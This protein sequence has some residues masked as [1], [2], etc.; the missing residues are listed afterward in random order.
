MYC[1]KRAIKSRFAAHRTNHTCYKNTTGNKKWESSV[2]IYGTDIPVFESVQHE[3]QNI[4]YQFYCPCS[5][6]VAWLLSTQGSTRPEAPQ[7]SH[8]RLALHTPPP[9]TPQ[10]PCHTHRLDTALGSISDC[11]S[12]SCHFLCRYLHETEQQPHEYR[13]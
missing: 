10:S 9:H 5:E 8:S 4:Y 3:A 7:W 2:D 6:A 13:G 12:R 11:W 1:I